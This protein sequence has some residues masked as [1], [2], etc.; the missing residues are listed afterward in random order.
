[1]KRKCIHLLTNEQGN[2]TMELN[3]YNP[4]QYGV[5]W[6]IRYKKD[7][8]SHYFWNDKNLIKLI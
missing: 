5:M 7:T 4:P 6:D 2:I 8:P 3:S 1:M